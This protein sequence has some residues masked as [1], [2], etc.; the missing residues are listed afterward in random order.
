M[1]TNK[2]K[3][4]LITRETFPRPDSQAPQSCQVCALYENSRMLEA[5]LQPDA[6]ESILHNIY[7]ARVRNVAANLNA[8]FVEIAKGTLCYLPFE[9]MKAPVFTRKISKKPVA[10]GD[11]LVVQVIKEAVKTKD[12]VATTNL[13]FS[14]EYLVLT[15]A[16]KKIGVSSKLRKDERDRLQA[17]AQELRGEDDYGIIVRTNAGNV[18]EDSIKEELRQLKEEY[19]QVISSAPSRTIYSCLRKERPFYQKM[20]VDTDKSTLEE[21]VTDDPEIFRQLQRLFPEASYGIRLYEDRLLPLARL[22]NIAG[23]IEHA[24]KPR[25]WL[26]SG[27]NIIIQ[28]TEALTVIDVNS[29]RNTAKKEKQQNHFEINLEAAEEIARQLRLRCISGIIIVDFIDLYDDA[30]KEALL[31]AFRS[32]L[33]KDPVPVQ[34][35][36]MTR[37]GLVELTRK[38]QKKSLEEQLG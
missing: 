35:V 3:K 36:D 29:G 23:Q 1:N 31:A 32:Y 17:L 15:S 13:N 27:A 20:L 30:Q 2:G 8:A 24:R 5:V 33:K 18:P 16:N 4:L 25:V 26:R 6:S 21:V 11:E 22:Y 19:M 37:L 34:L 7:V 28:P 9:N 14:G 38:K 12:A 10:A